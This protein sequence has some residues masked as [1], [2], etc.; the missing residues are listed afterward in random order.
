MNF[1]RSFVEYFRGDYN[2]AHI[3][4]GLFTPAQLVSVGILVA[5]VTLAVVLRGMKSKSQIP[6]PK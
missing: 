1:T 6:N 3:H 5:G 2:T 4:G